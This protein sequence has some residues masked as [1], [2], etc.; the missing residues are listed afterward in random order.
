MKVSILTEAGRNIGFGHLTR[1]IALYQ[2]F[3]EE[4]NNPELII[5]GDKGILG[6]VKDKSYQIMDWIKERD[7]LREIVTGSDVVVLDSY[8]APKSVYDS[9]SDILSSR[10]NPYHLSRNPLLMIDDYQRIDYPK[11]IVVNPSIYGDKLEY[12]KKE[13]VKYLLGKDYIILRRPFWGIPPKAI[14]KE[15]KNILITLGGGNNED[16]LSQLLEFLAKE[17]PDF[18]YHLITNHNLNLDLDLNLNLYSGLSAS[19]ILELMLKADVCISGGGQTTY[20]LARVGLPTI[21]ICFAENQ[22]NNLRYGD[23]TGYLK[24]VGDSDE[25]N[26]F[27]KIKDVL[28]KITSFQQRAKMNTKGLENIDGIGCKRII[29]SG[30]G[31]AKNKTCM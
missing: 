20:E 7:E 4:N 31:N 28:E 21:G 13:G 3:E 15:V 2:A 8:L 11:G 24:Y 9:I 25:D 19:G 10:S 23:L 27:N 5:N 18:T 17:F 26:L 12:S 22:I 29:N 16:F 30:L 6:F 14:N 1:C